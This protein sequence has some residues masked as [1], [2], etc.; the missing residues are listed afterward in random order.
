MTPRQIAI[1]VVAALVLTLIFQ[2]FYIVDQREQAI[3]VRF[4]DPA[5]VVNSPASPGAGLK[6]KVP[7]IEQVIKLDRRNIALEAQQEEIITSGQ[8]RL[9]VDAFLRYRISDPLQFYRSLRDEATAADRL[10]RLL[11]SSLRQVLGSAS[12]TDIVSGQRTQLMQKARA[13]MAQRAQASRLGIEVIDVRIK[14]ADLPDEN[15]TN[16]LRRMQTSR[17]QYA[18]ETRAEGEQRKREIIAEADRE[19]SV[20]L[21]TAREEAGKV[22]GEGDA[23]RTRIFANSFGKDASFAAFFRSMQAYEQSFADGQTT[24]VLSP[25]SAFFRYF[26]RGPTAGSR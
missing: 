22:T 23:Q 1:G 11:N 7:F 9:V 12:Q 14:R 18:A 16:V 10:A 25:D 5:R 6:L 21:A 3:V 13:D 8:Q 17:Q 19:V 24:M 26:E 2:T 15:R 20:T 4:G